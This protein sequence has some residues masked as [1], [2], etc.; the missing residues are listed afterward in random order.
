MDILLTEFR[1]LSYQPFQLFP[2][3]NYLYICVRQDFAS[4]L[5]KIIAR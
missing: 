5:Q 1:V 3:G 4:A 2:R